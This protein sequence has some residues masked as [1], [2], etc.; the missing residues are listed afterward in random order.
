M[1]H[2]SFVGLTVALYCVSVLQGH[3]QNYAAAEI[4][5]PLVFTRH[6]HSKT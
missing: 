6:S 5:R 2:R 1:T 3:A 4:V